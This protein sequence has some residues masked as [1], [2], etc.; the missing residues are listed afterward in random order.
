M[1]H[2]QQNIFPLQ[3]Q[4]PQKL[5]TSNNQLRKIAMCNI[6]WAYVKRMLKF[7]EV[8]ATLKAII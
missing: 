3:I 4:K 2:S 7:K 1:P 5:Q 6:I 8:L